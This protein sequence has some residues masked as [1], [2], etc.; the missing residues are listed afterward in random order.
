[1]DDKKKEAKEIEIPD[2]AEDCDI[3]IDAYCKRPPLKFFWLPSNNE[4]R[5]DALFIDG[6]YSAGKAIAEGVIS[7]SLYEGIEGLA[8]LFLFR[9]YLELQL[10]FIIF[11]ARW[12]KDWN[13]NAEDEEVQPVG[14]GHPLTPLWETLQSECKA[15]I[16][17]EIWNSFDLEFVDNC[18]KEFDKLDPRSEAFRYPT[19][20]KIR[21]QT[22]APHR[23]PLRISFQ[24][25]LLTME[26]V[27]SVLDWIDMYLI[28]RYH[29]NKEWKS[30]QDSY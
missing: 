18:V 30:I 28:E 3:V 10:K 17:S 1:M 2:A 15:R 7:G 9:H 4:W 11:H 6:Y 24:E 19:S 23:E 20:D 21:V 8:A 16:P 29:E 22:G 25:L 12:M 26:H 5:V 13:N 27:R 14:K